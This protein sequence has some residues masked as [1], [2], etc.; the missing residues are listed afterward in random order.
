[1]AFIP[2]CGMIYMEPHQLGWTPLRDSYMDT[3]PSSLATEHKEL[4]RPY[5]RCGT[6]FWLGC[7]LLFYKIYFWQTCHSWQCGSF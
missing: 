3:L 2:R 4:V 6:V 7:L 1:M 5:T